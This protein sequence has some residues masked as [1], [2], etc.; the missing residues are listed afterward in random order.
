MATENAADSLTVMMIREYENKCVV[1]AYEVFDY[2]ILNDIS[3]VLSRERWCR[4]YCNIVEVLEREIEALAENRAF[5]HDRPLADRVG[6]IDKSVEEMDREGFDDESHLCVTAIKR[7]KQWVYN[8]RR[9][10]ERAEKNI[11]KL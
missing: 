2:Y 9:A 8:A 3:R 1:A 4:S 5:N 10:L 11:E 6:A 7:C